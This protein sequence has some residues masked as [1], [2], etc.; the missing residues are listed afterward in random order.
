[1]NKGGAG[2]NQSA[3]NRFAGS[4]AFV[5]AAR[6]AFAVIE[7]PEDDERRLLLQAKN[8]LGKSCKGLA[9]RLEQR[10]MP[11]DIVSSNVMF[12][13]EHV[14]QSIDEAL[15]ASESRGGNKGLRED[16]G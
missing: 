14:S 13:G 4:I 11:G 12:E 5:A 9:F 7:D 1:L 10:Q 16:L 15:V 8:N 6:A 3:L 2:G